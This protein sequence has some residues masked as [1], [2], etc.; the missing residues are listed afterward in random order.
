ML[1][2][3]DKKGANMAKTQ[4]KAPA[5]GQWTSQLGFI[6]AALGSAV[7]LGNIWRFPGV[8]YENGGGAFLIPYIVALLTA[9]IPILLLDYAIGHRFRGS[10]PQALRRAAGRSGEA[11]GWF[12]VM[13][14]VFI[15]IYY[16]AVV[17][18]T[19][20]YFVFSFNLK[21]TS[22]DSAADF[23][24]EDYLHASESQFTLDIVP[25]VLIPLVLFWIIA[26][27]ILAG[28]VAKGV[29]RANVI[30]IPLLVVSFLALV[31]GSLFLPGAAEGLNAFFTPD[32]AALGHPKVWIAAY[33]Q[34]FFSLSVAF[35]IM[36]TYSSYRKRR[37]NLSGPGLVVA[38][39]NSSFEL[40]AG[41][42][43]FAALGFFAS[44]GGTSVDQLEGLTGVGLAF[45]TFPAIVAEMPIA[46]LFGILFFGSLLL[47]GLTSLISILE[48]TIAGLMDKFFLSRKAAVWGFGGLLAVISVILFSTTSGLY[49]LDTIDKFANE[50][51]IVT[52]AIVM[53]VL[54]IWV[55]RRGPE[56]AQHVSAI[57]TFRINRTWRLLV[58]IVSPVVITVMLVQVIIGIINEGYEGY[59]GW[60]LSLFGWGAVAVMIIAAFILTMLPWKSDPA[61]YRAWPP[62]S[63]TPP[64]TGS[65]RVVDARSAQSD[66]ASTA[67]GD[68][69]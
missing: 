52:S 9:G 41:I 21:W 46:P 35:G 15:A 63:G 30:F 50:I 42:G 32:F 37:S 59:P 16:T 43:V 67:Q 44:Q 48:V 51:G 10:A 60:Y 58:G 12:Q 69:L 6:F 20:S 5:R 4:V 49:A 66:G 31:V 56:L 53:C 65:H 57:S 2:A 62:I 68:S 61:N 27:A 18:W 45:M 28:G 24:T 47:A 25:G 7:G 26:L 38:F 22:R 33:G 34:I 23:F 55:Y 29:Q 1:N 11:L 14:C 54:T 64:T 3:R 13:I 40:L 8:A 17:A 36:L 39:G 19:A